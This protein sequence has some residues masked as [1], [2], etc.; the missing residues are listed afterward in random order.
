MALALWLLSV[1]LI[2]GCDG[3]TINDKLMMNLGTTNAILTNHHVI[4]D[5]SACIENKQLII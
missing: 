4:N 5:I 1:I 3:E 2:E